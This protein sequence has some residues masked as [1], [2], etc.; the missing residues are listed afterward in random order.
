[1]YSNKT[2]Y[3]YISRT[4]FLKIKKF[5]KGKNTPFLV[6]DL[7]K[8]EKRYNEIKKHLSF[9]KIY[10]AVKSNPEDEIINLLNKKGSNFDVAT[11]F[12]LDQLLK[13]KIP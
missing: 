8:I 10:Y 5:A 4:D 13:H 7:N 12:E 6:M 2:M 1:M 3:D 9:A 11:I